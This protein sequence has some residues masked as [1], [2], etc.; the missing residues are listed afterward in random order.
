MK[1]TRPSGTRDTHVSSPPISPVLPFSH[2]SDGLVSHCCRWWLVRPLAAWHSWID[3]CSSS[4][5]LRRTIFI[6]RC[7]RKK[8][9]IGLASSSRLS[10]S[11]FLWACKL[12]KWHLF[13]YCRGIF[14]P[15]V[16][17]GDS[18]GPL[19]LWLSC[20]RETW[21]SEFPWPFKSKIQ[22]RS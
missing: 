18:K 8:K 7:V 6:L 11:V 20:G 21:N 4:A 19:Y 22:K 12:S 15:L 10:T 9:M 17:A 13:Y 3:P 16:Q 5:G 1:S 14:I 2:L